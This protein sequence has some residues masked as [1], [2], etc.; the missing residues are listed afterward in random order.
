MMSRSNKVRKMTDD[1]AITYRQAIEE[2]DSILASIESTDVD[3]DELSAKVQRAQ[4]LIEVCTGRI[5]KAQDDVE[6]V[7]SRLDEGES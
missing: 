7:I 5:R 3:V 6:K 1:Q 4:H 2:L